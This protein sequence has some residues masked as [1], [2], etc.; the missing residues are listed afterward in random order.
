MVL[1][2]WDRLLHEVLIV[3]KRFWWVSR[4]SYIL[5]LDREFFTVHGTFQRLLAAHVLPYDKRWSFSYYVT[6]KTVSF[7]SRIFHTRRKKLIIVDVIY[8]MPFEDFDES[9]HT[10]CYHCISITYFFLSC[11]I[12]NSD[13]P[14]IFT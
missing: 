2:V 6:C 8:A 1:A 4:R 11:Y 9:C 7:S 5:I 13:L 14:Y 12:H 10:S 3:N